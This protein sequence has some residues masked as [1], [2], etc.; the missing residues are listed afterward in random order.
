MSEA[1]SWLGACKGV[2][3][4]EFGVTNVGGDSPEIVQI[5]K[6]LT[7]IR[8]R[9]ELPRIEA[10]NFASETGGRSSP[11]RTKIVHDMPVSESDSEDDEVWDSSTMTVVGRDTE[12]MND[13][14]VSESD[15]E[16]DEIPSDRT[17][18]V[19]QGRYP[20]KM[21]KVTICQECNNKDYGRNIDRHMRTHLPDDSPEKMAWRKHTNETQG[22]WANTRYNENELFS[23]DKKCR[24][25]RDKENIKCIKEGR[26]RVPVTGEPKSKVSN[27]IM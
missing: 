17:T 15:S 16:D 8:P 14:P 3:F 12:N 6:E 10:G 13:M 11:K 26:E 27:V 22:A 7:R 21:K 19:N 4:G 20:E 18:W 25:R 1:P 23:S 24:S 5:P 9:E 2:Q